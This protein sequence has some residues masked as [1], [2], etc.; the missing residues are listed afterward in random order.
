VAADWQRTR[1]EATEAQLRQLLLAG[2]Q[3]ARQR[4]ADGNAAGRQIAIA[5]PTDLASDGAQL[6]LVPAAANG[7]ADAKM[8]VNA[9]YAGH[10]SSEQLQFHRGDAGWALVDVA[11]NP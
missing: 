1:A 5:L 11:M 7:P 9:Q 2:C 3:A 8:A 10:R 4:L 6:V